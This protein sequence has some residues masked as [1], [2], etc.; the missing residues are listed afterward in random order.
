[1][2][3]KDIDGGMDDAKALLHA[4]GWDICVNKNG[5]LVKGGY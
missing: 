2:V 5:K 4:K 1:M 3:F